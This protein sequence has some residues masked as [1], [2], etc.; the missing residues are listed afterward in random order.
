MRF[1]STQICLSRSQSV[2]SLGQALYDD[3]FCFNLEEPAAP[4]TVLQ[5]IAVSIAIFSVQFC[6]NKY[7]LRLE[8]QHSFCYINGYSP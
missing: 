6:E 8:L 5:S 2:D 4:M 7:Q 1:N 3:F